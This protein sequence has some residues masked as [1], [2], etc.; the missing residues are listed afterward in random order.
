[1]RDCAKNSFAAGTLVLMADGSRKRIEDVGVGDEVLAT[2]PETGESGAR[3]VTALHRN[4]DTDMADVT[5]RTADGHET[6][7][8]ATQ[9]HPFW[10]ETRRAW[11][12]AADLKAGDNLISPDGKS[13]YVVKVRSFAATKYMY[14]LTVA[15]LHVLSTRLANW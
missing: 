14:N 7:I 15:G 13:A 6:T 8:H 11:V 3:K 12:D 10:D 4:K 9:H 5:I 2:D 1:M